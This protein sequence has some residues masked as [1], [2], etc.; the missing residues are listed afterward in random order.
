MNTIKVYKTDGTLKYTFLPSSASTQEADGHI[1]SQSCYMASD[2]TGAELEGGS[3][4]FEVLSKKVLEFSKGEKIKY[5]SG[6]ELFGVF[7]VETSERTAETKWHVTGIDSIAMLEN[8]CYYGVFVTDAPLE[9]YLS[10]NLRDNL[11]IPVTVDSALSDFKVTA[12]YPSGYN[13]TNSDVSPGNAK[14]TPTQKSSMRELFQMMAFGYGFRFDT[15]KNEGVKIIPDPITYNIEKIYTANDLYSDASV[16][17]KSNDVGI[18]NLYRQYLNVDPQ[19]GA[20]KHVKGYFP[21]NG[22]AKTKIDPFTASPALGREFEANGIKQQA[23]ND[24][25][26]NVNPKKQVNSIITLFKDGIKT[27]IFPDGKITTAHYFTAIQNFDGSFTYQIDLEK[28]AEVESYFS[29]HYPSGSGAET[30][31]T[32]ESGVRYALGVIGWQEVFVPDSVEGALPYTFE[33]K[34]TII[35]DKN[36]AKNNIIIPFFSDDTA[37]RVDVYFGRTKEVSF[38]VK[39][40]G[41]KLGDIVSIPAIWGKSYYCA[42][43]SMDF[44]FSASNIFCNIV[45]DVLSPEEEKKIVL[46]SVYGTAKYGTAKYM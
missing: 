30:T 3:C 21:I 46:P 9:K 28:L 34:K 2:D 17:E 15:L 7:F 32:D 23:E 44:T 41:E 16:T 5:Y 38:K 29:T 8:A 19:T 40:S 6:G 18:I 35:Y 24:L 4:D 10:D 33:H 11:N 22:G 12:S 43:K 36:K 20:V 14:T 42:I 27:E 26:G 13:D 45:A 31:Y 25:T 1:S 39:Y 37:N